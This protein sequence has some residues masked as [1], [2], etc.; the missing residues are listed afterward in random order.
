MSQSDLLGPLVDAI[1]TVKRRIQ[2]HGANLRENETR[3]RVAL[4]DPILEALGWDVSDP[5]AVI[6]EYDVSGRRADYALLRDDGKPAATVEQLLGLT[7]SRTTVHEAAL[8]LLLLWRPNLESGEPNPP[9]LAPFEIGEPS[10]PAPPVLEPQISRANLSPSLVSAR[11][12]DSCRL[13]ETRDTVLP[14][15]D[16]WK[17][18]DEVLKDPKRKRQVHSDGKQKRV[19]TPKP[20]KI[21]FPNGQ[22]AD[23]RY[24][25]DVLLRVAEWISNSANFAR[26]LLPVMCAGQTAFGR[27]DLAMKSPKQV[28]PDSQLYIE[29][30]LSSRDSAKAAIEVLSKFSIEPSSVRIRSS[31]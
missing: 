15:P 21:H 20:K 13:D 16:Y 22:V 31:L 23:L 12:S 9:Q 24:A 17:R 29:T 3:T 1:E 8:K 19:P 7:L 28:S 18:I 25:Y 27:G 26:E 5:S 6:L 4:I 14:L 30:K 10:R 2:E 11:T